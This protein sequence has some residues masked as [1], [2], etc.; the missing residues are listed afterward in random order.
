[1]EAI[2][3]LAE[4]GIPVVFLR[5]RPRCM[6]P[7]QQALFEERLAAVLALPNAAYVD[8]YRLYRQYTYR[9]DPGCLCAAE[10]FEEA[11]QPLVRTEGRI[12]G[13]SCMAREYENGR[14]YFLVNEQDGERTLRGRFRE[15]GA[16]VIWEALTGERHACPYRLVRDGVEL[17]LALPPYGS[18]LVVFGDDVPSATPEKRLE[19]RVYLDGDWTL[20]IDG[21]VLTGE[22][23]GWEEPLPTY[24]GEGV[25]EY[26]VELGEEADAGTAVL[27]LAEVNSL[28]EAEINGQSAGVLLWRPY[29]L[30]TGLF[31]AGT[32]HIRLKAV[33]TL[34]NAYEGRPLPSGIRGPAVLDLLR[35][36][37]K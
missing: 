35:E 1:M 36:E 33:N 26:T 14:V 23:C 13:V 3:R 6:D 25:Y 20:R 4:R 27:S 12:S 7:A 17:A 24:S 34:A 21:Q 16:P 22:L 30:E 11:V 29:R 15:S 18:M 28:C 37:S 31:H 5:E 32:N 8:D 19:R 2:A 9:F 10:G